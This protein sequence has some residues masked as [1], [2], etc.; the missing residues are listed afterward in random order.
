MSALNMTGDPWLLELGM[1]GEQQRSVAKQVLAT[2]IQISRR[3]GHVLCFA[4]KETRQRVRR[5]ARVGQVAYVRVPCARCGIEPRLTE[6]LAASTL[7]EEGARRLA[8][9][10]Y[11]TAQE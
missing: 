10:A 6:W 3:W 11:E 1:E 2:S 7:T 9:K 5:D 8:E 4:D